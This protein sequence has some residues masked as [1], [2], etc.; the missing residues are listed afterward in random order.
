MKKNRKN[1]NKQEKQKISL[2]KILKNWW[3][4]KHPIL[5]FMLVF[6]ALMT[7]FYIV[8]NQSFFIN[9]LHPKLLNVNANISSFV[10]NIIGQNTS[11]GATAITSSAFA[12]DIK[13]G[14]DALEPIALLMSAILAYPGA[15]GKKMVGILISVIILFVINIVRIVSLFLIG[16]YWN[17]IFDVMHVEVWQFLFILLVITLCFIWIKWTARTSISKLELNV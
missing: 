15:I 10:L 12:I 7:V 2:V 1:K 9:N 6:S 13:Q 11:V 17:N 4:V 5:L 3:R 14:C 8:I 16:V